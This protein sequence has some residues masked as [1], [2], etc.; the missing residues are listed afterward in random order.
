MSPFIQFPPDLT[1]DLASSLRPISRN[2]PVL[3]NAASPLFTLLVVTEQ[4]VAEISSTQSQSL[5]DLEQIERHASA[6]ELRDFTAW[7]LQR[8]HSPSLSFNEKL[9]LL[10]IAWKVQKLLWSVD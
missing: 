6:T 7:A 1:S 8:S 5:H 3:Q 4:N 10:D 9:Q 2:N